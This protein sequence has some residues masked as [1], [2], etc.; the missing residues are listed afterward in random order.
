M[1]YLV[2]SQKKRVSHK[3]GTTRLRSLQ[4]KKASLRII[5]KATSQLLTLCSSPSLRRCRPAWISWNGSHLSCNFFIRSIISFS[6]RPLFESRVA[7]DTI[8]IAFFVSSKSSPL[9]SWYFK[10]V[11][12]RAL[13]RSVSEKAGILSQPATHQPQDLVLRKI[14]FWNILSKSWDCKRPPTWLGQSPPFS[15]HFGGRLS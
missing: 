12:T 8:S 9:S 3:D 10:Y 2:T 15:K 6:R 13:Q 14:I 5:R 4:T 11:S 7:L 1:L